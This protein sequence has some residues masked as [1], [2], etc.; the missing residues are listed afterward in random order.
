MGCYECDS[1]QGN[2]I[3]NHAQYIPTYDTPNP[4]YPQKYF[5]Q[6]GFYS[7]VGGVM[8]AEYGILC[9]GEILMCKA[10]LRI[11]QRHPRNTIVKW[12][13]DCH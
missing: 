12:L 1:K 6:V 3:Y 9:G 8:K 4:K 10:P 13:S 11:L 2:Y 7:G 5:I